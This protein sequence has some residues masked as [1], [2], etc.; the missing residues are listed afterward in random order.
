LRSCILFLT[1]TATLFPLAAERVAQDLLFR[2]RTTI[3]TNAKEGT[4]FDAVVTG[5]VRAD[6]VPLLPIGSTLHGRAVQVQ[7]VGIGV[8]HERAGLQLKF[9]SCTL[10]DGTA[11]PCRPQLISFDNAQE[12]VLSGN[13]V[14]GIL[15]AAHPHSLL[16][17]LWGRP[18]SAIISRSLSGVSGRMFYTGTAP[19]PILAGAIIVSRITIFR[20]PDPEIHLPAGTEMI[21][22]VFGDAPEP[23]SG[24]DPSAIPL[25]LADWLKH[26]YV[27]IT[28]PD[29]KPATDIINFAFRGTKAEISEAFIGAGW[30]TADP[31]TR[32]SFVRSYTSYTSFSPYPTAPVS[33]LRYQG[34]VADLVFQKSFNTMAKRHHI[35]L[36]EVDSPDGPLWLGA[37]THDI[38]LAFDWKRLALTHRIDV[39]IDRERDK[40]L[41]DLKFAGCVSSAESLPRPRLATYSQR[42][43]T[44]GALQ[45]IGVQ[46]CLEPTP[47]V[48]P[49]AGRKRTA[50]GKSIVRQTVL[51]SR[52]YFLR[53][54][55][56]Y[57][58]YRGL[59]SRPVRAFFIRSKPTLAA[60][61]RE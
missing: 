4:P 18:T 23:P 47:H 40:I 39:S 60:F 6:C 32:R 7:P 41:A 50:P 20:L 43:A 61:R 28:L 36:W 14:E 11:Q 51:E 13:R 55:I 30:V 2:L 10:T 26:V 57:W 25:D 16:G 29:G 45:F 3:T 46:S 17:S 54:N 22:R 48:N 33:P 52:H 56:Y 34:Q 53:G 12:T 9:D 21:L 15:A 1:I 5:C 27:S 44:D 8:R 35:R 59:R 42:L 31:L 19:H 37:A 24:S 49:T 58:A 38:S